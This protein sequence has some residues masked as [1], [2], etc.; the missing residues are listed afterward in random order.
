MVSKLVGYI[1]AG[2]GIVVIALS[3]TIQKLVPIIPATPPYILLVGA[4]IV[5]LGIVFMMNLGKKQEKEV[6]I[7]DKH[8]KNIVGYRRLK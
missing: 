6:P 3:Q 7:Y 4:A 5:I 8:G 1:L 2:V